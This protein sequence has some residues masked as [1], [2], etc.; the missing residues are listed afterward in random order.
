MQGRCGPHFRRL[1]EFDWGKP[2]PLLGR[3]HA[4]V[5]MINGG[6]AKNVIPDRC[7]F[8]LD[9][10]TTPLEDHHI[11]FER[12]QRAMTSDLRI[13]SDR[14]VP[15]STG[16]NERIVG[17]VLRALPGATPAGS[18]AMSDMV[19]LDGVPAVKIGPGQSPRSHTPDE[20]V[21]RDELAAGQRF[22]SRFLELAPVAQPA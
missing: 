4:H 3:C 7:E 22:Y 13:H 10:R 8:W 2:H 6:V 16:H 17:A 18:S 11:L 5:T 9:I 21:T 1:R 12:L 20:F 15:I 14:L 19:F